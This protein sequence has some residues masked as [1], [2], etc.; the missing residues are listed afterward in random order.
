L[1]DCLD[2]RF[3]YR[4][5][6]G[7]RFDTSR[8]GH[9]RLA[10]PSQP[11]AAADNPDAEIIEAGKAFELL[12]SKYLDARFVWQSLPGR[13]EPGRTRSSPRMMLTGQ[14]A[15]IRNGIFVRSLCE[16]N[17]C[18]KASNRVS[19]IFEEMEP[20]GD[21]IRDA[22]AETLEGLRAKTLVA[23]SDC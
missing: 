22:A 2:L 8:S 19:A 17:G 10:I 21:L 20:L 11:A 3:E 1:C 6:Q 13:R 7:G 4:C 18:R 16:Q 9:V 14:A 5:T 15:T 23:V 12:L